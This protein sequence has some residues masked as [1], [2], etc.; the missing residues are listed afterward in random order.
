MAISTDTVLQALKDGTYTLETI[1]SSRFFK[2]K[3]P[4]KRRKYPSVEL[5]E[6]PLGNI[7]A[8]DKSSFIRKFD[9]RIFLGL[10]GGTTTGQ[11][12]EI[13]DLETLEV[14]ILDVMEGISLADHKI[15]VDERVWNRT[16]DNEGLRPFIKSVL[17]VT[18]RQVTSTGNTSPDGILVY[19][20]SESTADNK[21]VSDYTY[22]N[23]YSVDINEGYNDIDESINN[24][25]NPQRFT[26]DF[27]GTFI[28]NLKVKAVDLGATS[29]KLNQLA[30]I[31]ANGEKQTV[32]F[33]YTNKTAD[34]PTTS[35]IQ[36]IIKLTIDQ[37][38]EIYRVN[39]VTTIRILGKL[40]EPSAT[41][42][43]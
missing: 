10:R 7:T 43:I 37:T 2:T 14:E 24:T 12:D 1:V 8:D 39:D 18:V 23:V 41:T 40:L 9:V 33:I 28:G 11:E 35:N 38:Q 15:V 36:R 3:Q 21:P 26:G 6:T 31:Q 22:D 19:D 27:F 17:T 34:S 32:G 25:A 42:V 30:R 5:L 16:Y 4:D 13:T 20:I 29:E